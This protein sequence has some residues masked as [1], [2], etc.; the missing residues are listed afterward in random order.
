MGLT[1]SVRSPRTAFA[2]GLVALAAAVGLPGTAQAATGT[3]GQ[4][5]VARIVGGTLSDPDAWP[6]QVALLRAGEPDP[7]LAQF[8]AGTLVAKDWVLTSAR[9]VVKGE[10][11]GT[12]AR[13]GSIRVAAGRSMLRSIGPEAK[14]RVDRIVVNPRYEWRDEWDAARYDAALLHLSRDLP[15]P[16]ARLARPQDDGT[17]RIGSVGTVVGWGAKAFGTGDFARHLRET[18]VPVLGD[19][20]CKQIY[21]EIKPGSTLCAGWLG[22]GK[23]DA[24]DGDAGGPLWVRTGAG[25]RQVGIVSNGVGCGERAFP[26]TYGDVRGMFTWISQNVP[27]VAD[28]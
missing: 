7:W 26:G 14:V 19:T 8:C 2:A 4:P 22:V 3:D 25:R 20:R 23:R 17:W 18:K 21:P 5:P 24:C 13:P 6:M 28:R 10:T 1:A 12:V 11:P 9:C 15:G 16:Y 27:A